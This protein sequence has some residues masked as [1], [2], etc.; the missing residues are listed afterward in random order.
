[1]N[2][3]LKKTFFPLITCLA[4]AA[5]TAPVNPVNTA[6]SGTNSLSPTDGEI[7]V[8]PY[9]HLEPTKGQIEILDKT[10]KIIKAKAT[11]GAALNFQKWNSDGQVRYTYTEYAPAANSIIT[12][13]NIPGSVVLLD[14][15]LNELKR[16]RLL[17]FNGRT[18]DSPNDV[19][20]HDFILINDNHYLVMAYYVKKAENIPPELKPAENARVISAIIQ[21]VDNGQV[22]FEWDSSNYPELY[23]ASLENNNY[24]DANAINDYVHMNSMYIDPADG[25]LICSF[26]NLSQVL[27]LDRKTGGIIWKLGGKNSDFPLTEDQTFYFQ[28]D[29]TLTDNSKTLLLFDNGSSAKRPYTR[30]LEFQLDE[31]NKKV[32]SFKALKAPE[33]IFSMYMG[34]VQKRG[35]TY[36]I[37][38]GSVPRLSEINYKTGAVTFDMNLEQNSYRTFKY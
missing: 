20:G 17:P 16:I 14:Q 35:D 9:D 12:Q 5:C 24:S 27:K 31:L 38:W 18:A 10:G 13:S 2:L 29:A 32:N 36:F 37:G 6:T 8:A 3:T 30:I 4:L 19:D 23:G 34:S 25:N 11:K 7:L 22:V 21:E 1:M 28:H 33:N 26:R 15:D